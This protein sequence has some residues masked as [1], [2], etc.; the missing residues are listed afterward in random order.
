MEAQI[1]LE[2]EN[3]KMKEELVKINL[4]TVEKQ[5]ISEK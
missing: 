2:K 1:K 5:I 4:Q 3:E